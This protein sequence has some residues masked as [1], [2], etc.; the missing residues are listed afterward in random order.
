MMRTENHYI[1]PLCVCCEALRNISLANSELFPLSCLSG[2]FL[3]GMQYFD[4]VDLDDLLNEFDM[5][6]SSQVSGKMM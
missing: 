2:C 3:P 5:G 1:L 4:E 6:P